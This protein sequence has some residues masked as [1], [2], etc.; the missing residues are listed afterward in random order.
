MPVTSRVSTGAAVLAG[1]VMAVALAAGCAKARAATV[2]DGP[3]LAM[4]LPPPRVFSPIDEKPLDASPAVAEAPASEAP[5]VA[6][7]GRP[8]PA[9]NRRSR[10]SEKAEAPPPPAPVPVVEPARELRTASTP[11]DDEA[12]KKIRALLNAATRDL[13]KIDRGRLSTEGKEQYDQARSFATQGDA[14]LMQRNYVFAETL[15]VRAGRIAAEL[16]AR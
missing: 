4:P 14:A 3:P 8:D 5:N 2:P 10:E 6:T 15:A 11:T 1:V 13:E 16:L 9:T 12:N 7:P